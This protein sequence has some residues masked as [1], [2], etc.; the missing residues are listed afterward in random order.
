MTT[1][2]STQCFS[3]RS[4][5][6]STLKDWVINVKNTLYVSWIADIGGNHLDKCVCLLLI[7]YHRLIILL[8]WWSFCHGIFYIIFWHKSSRLIDQEADMK[9]NGLNYVQY[10]PVNCYRS[11]DTTSNTP[12]QF[13]ITSLIFNTRIC[14]ISW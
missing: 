5:V 6:I 13:P 8:F 9:G 7:G 3:N 4:N 2:R 14:I 1:A 12:W 11:Q 10:N